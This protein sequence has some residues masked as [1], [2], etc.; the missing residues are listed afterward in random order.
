MTLPHIR[1]PIFVETTF[2]V[3]QLF[4]PWMF[5]YHLYFSIPSGE[6]LIGDGGTPSRPQVAQSREKIVA[7]V[8]Y[9]QCIF[10]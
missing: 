7:N 9:G 5:C 4:S 6:A 3:H 1:L 10:V 8:A 2:H